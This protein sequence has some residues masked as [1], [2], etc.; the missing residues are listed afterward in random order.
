MVKSELVEEVARRSGS[1]KVAAAAM[2]DLI[3]EIVVVR[4]RSGE[5]FRTNELGIFSVVKKAAKNGRNPQ[6]GAAVKIPARNAVKFK[7]SAG[8]KRSVNKK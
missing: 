6:T 5:E 3:L 4:L 7:A 8:L 1:T 2:V